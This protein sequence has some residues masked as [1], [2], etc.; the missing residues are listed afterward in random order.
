M[1]KNVKRIIAVLL[2][3]TLSFGWP[4]SVEAASLEDEGEVD[5]IKLFDLDD[6]HLI[7]VV[8]SADTARTTSRPT[9][10]YYLDTQGQY[11]FS[12]Y[13]NNNIMWS[14]YIFRFKYENGYRFEIAGKCT[15]TNF[16]LVVCDNISHKDYYYKIKN[17]SFIVTC[18]DKGWEDWPRPRSF[19]FGIDTKS[20]GSAVSVDGIIDT[21]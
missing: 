10:I 4:V 2:F 8:D 15:N 11:S 6:P 19:Y 13:S 20:T 5:T 17:T 14:K 18:E 16:K 12:A 9:S 21:Y 3:V 1:L 7:E